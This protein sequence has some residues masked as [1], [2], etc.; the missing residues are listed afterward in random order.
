MDEERVIML[1]KNVAFFLVLILFVSA[2]TAVP[3]SGQALA[4]ETSAVQ[5]YVSPSGEDTTGDGSEGNPYQ[6]I[7][8]A[9]AVLRANK[10]SMMTE[11]YEI[12][13]REGTYVLNNTL[14][15][16]SVDSGNN[17]H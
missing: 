17:G 7:A 1:K 2:F 11:N 10:P 4:A 9:Q 12:V 13:L 3:L 16:T 5:I 14:S 6:T 8:K 15:L